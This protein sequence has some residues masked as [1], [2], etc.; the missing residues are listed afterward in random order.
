MNIE[1]INKEIEFLEKMQAWMLENNLDTEFHDKY[2]KLTKELGYWYN[3]QAEETGANLQLDESVM[4]NLDLM[5]QDL[6]NYKKEKENLLDIIEARHLPDEKED[7]IELKN[8][9]DEI[10]NIL[11]DIENRKWVDVEVKYDKI[12]NEKLDNLLELKKSKNQLK[13]MAKYNRKR[14]KGKGW[15]VKLNAGDPEYNAS[16]FNR[17][18]GNDTTSSSETS[19]SEG[20]GLAENIEPQQINIRQSLIELDQQDPEGF[21]IL[22]DIYDNIILNITLD[23]KK[24]LAELIIR[25]NIEDITDY[26]VKL[27]NKY[28]YG[29]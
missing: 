23:E 6:I 9:I 14:Q 22:S 27:S 20:T 10:D 8:E 3:K 5:R 11:K 2:V 12:F 25:D 4:S 28:N 1:N 16:F 7:I 21:G 24:K 13:D 29:E 19:S 26:L 18:M 17:A 15:F